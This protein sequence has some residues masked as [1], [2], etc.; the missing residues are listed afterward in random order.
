MNKISETTFGTLPNGDAISLFTLTVPDKFE[1]EI[2]NI[3]GIIKSLKVPDRKGVM[4]NVVLGFETLGEYLNGHPYFGA[5]IGRF[6][7]RIANGV[8]S[9]DGNTYTLVKNNGNAHLHGGIKGFDKVLW[10]SVMMDDGS[11]KLTYLSPDGEEGYP[12]NLNVT[13]IYSIVDEST[14]RVEYHAICD[15][16]TPVNLTSHAYFNLSGDLTAK[17]HDHSLQINAYHYLPVD[18]DQIPVGQLAPVA[19][20][21]F[22]FRDLKSIGP[23]LDTLPDGFDHTFVLHNDQSMFI[24][25]GRLIHPVSGRIMDVYTTEPGIQFYSG[26]FLNGSLSGYNGVKYDKHCA[27]CLETQHYPDSPNQ[28]EFPNTILRPGETFTSTTEYRFGVE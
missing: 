9:L 8:F 14:L 18:G 21:P 25:A 10:E 1:V 27:L 24:H 16:S 11:L 20:S 4:Q 12:G 15:K 7:N 2:I 22:D 3:G 26:N 19:G 13:V 28:P 6:G 17:I 5:L 23:A